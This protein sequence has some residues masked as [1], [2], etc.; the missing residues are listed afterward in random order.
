MILI[1]YLLKLEIPCILFTLFS[2]SDL[3]L[4]RDGRSRYFLLSNVSTIDID[5]FSQRNYRVKCDNKGN[6][7]KRK[8]SSCNAIQ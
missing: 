8:K 2:C 3:D 1:Y 6:E 4:K 5:V 7:Q